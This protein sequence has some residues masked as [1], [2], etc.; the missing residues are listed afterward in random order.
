MLV[1]ST[2]TLDFCRC[3]LAKWITLRI[4][5]WIK[6]KSPLLQVFCNNGDMLV[7][8]ELYAYNKFGIGVWSW[9]NSIHTLYKS[10][11]YWKTQSC[12]GSCVFYG[13]KSVKKFC[14]LCFIKTCGS[15]RKSYFTEVIQ[16][17]LQI[18]IAIFNGITQNISKNSWNVIYM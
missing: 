4:L 18:T 16:N 3:K 1:F 13:V 11:C 15:V 14:N 5:E 2:K 17:Y 8:I 10:S 7:L 6:K 12:R 9:N